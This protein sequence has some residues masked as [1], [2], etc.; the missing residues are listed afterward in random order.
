MFDKLD[1]LL[2]RYEELE[3]ELSDPMVTSDA[4][5]FR[6]LMKEQSDIQPIVEAYKAYKDAKQNIQDS[7]FL[8]ES[9]NDEE[10]RELA[11]EELA[12]SKADVVELEAKLKILLLP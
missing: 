8:L 9:E 7:L 3:L 4:A 10:L 5:K 6:K 12:Q 1:D 11:K 2:K